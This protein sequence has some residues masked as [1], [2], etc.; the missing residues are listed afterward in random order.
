M[1]KNETEQGPGFS[2]QFKNCKCSI[3]SILILYESYLIISY[4][5]VTKFVERLKSYLI[6]TLE[7]DI[8][9]K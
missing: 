9:L 3:I 5:V 6:F 7:V 2:S 8:M 1:I 4:P